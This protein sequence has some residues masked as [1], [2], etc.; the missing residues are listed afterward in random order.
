MSLTPAALASVI[1]RFKDKARKLRQRQERIECNYA[2]TTATLE[3][4]K[5]IASH[6]KA[7]ADITRTDPTRGNGNPGIEPKPHST[8]W[9]VGNALQSVP[10]DSSRRG[11]RR[12]YAKLR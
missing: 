4:L 2:E 3:T 12:R 9:A 11:K 8:G 6:R 1:Q 10:Q 5:S 7:G